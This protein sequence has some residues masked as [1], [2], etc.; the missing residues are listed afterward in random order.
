M[1]SGDR[2]AVDVAN[3]VKAA[4]PR[5]D[6]MDAQIARASIASEL[7]GAGDDKP[8]V[9]RFLVQ[10]QLGAGAMG[11]VYRAWDPELGRH[12]AIK[13]LRAS[14]QFGETSTRARDRLLREARAMANVTHA[15]VLTVY[16]AG[17]VGD[18]VFVAMELAA[19]GTLREW[20]RREQPAWRAIIDRFLQ[21]AR[22]LEAA[23]AAKLV[24]R[25][26]K[27]DNVLIDAGGEARVADFGLVSVSAET[28][29]EDGTLGPPALDLT[30]TRAGALV[31]TPAYM[32]PEQHGSDPV[33]PAADQ[34]AFCVS[35]YEA[36]YG[37]RPFA[38]TSMAELAAAVTSGEVPPPPA[39][40]GVPEW[41]HQILVRGLAVAPGDRWPSMTALIEALSADPIAARRRRRAQIVVGA[42]IV[43]L[44][45]LATFGF[46]RGSSDDRPRCPTSQ[47]RLSGVWDTN[48]RGAVGQAFR[49]TGRRY[50]DDTFTRVASHLDDYT[51]TWVRERD[52]A[53]RATHQ[54]GEQSSVLLDL[55]MRCY[56]RR[57]RE[58]DRLVDLLAAGPDVDVL[59]RAVK[60]T[61]SLTPLAEC[62]DVDALR[63]P[64][65]LPSAPALRARVRALQERLEQG[66]MWF[67]AGKRAL[68]AKRLAELRSSVGAT[69]YLPLRAQTAFYSAYTREFH[70]YGA[71]YGDVMR[72]YEL[73][74]RL[75]ARAKL[76]RIVALAWIRMIW[77]RGYVLSQHGKALALRVT[78]EVAVERAG[79]ED[80]LRAKL[81][82]A[83]GVIYDERGERSRAQRLFKR[84]LALRRAAYGAEHPEIA[85]ALNN[86]ADSYRQAGKLRRALELHKRSLAMKTRLLGATHP[87]AGASLFNL[88][89]TSLAL[90]NYADALS[91][92]RRAGK[93]LTLR[94]STGVPCLVTAAIAKV[95]QAQRQYARAIATLE[96]ALAACTEQQGKS[97]AIKAKVLTALGEAHMQTGELDVAIT[98][99]RRAVAMFTKVRGE[100]NHSTGL[101]LS[102]L[103][104][105]LLER[106]KVGE[107]E[108][109]LKRALAVLSAVL[110][111]N[112]P[113]TCAVR[114][115]LGRAQLQKHALDAAATRFRRV[116][117]ALKAGRFD[118]AN[119]LASALF[120]L[121]EI[122]L[123]RAK[124][125]LAVD[126]A[127]RA[128]AEAE[129]GRRNERTR[130]WAHFMLAR[131]LLNQDRLKALYHGRQAQAWM[132]KAPPVARTELRMVEAWLDRHGANKVPR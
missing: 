23:H 58:V 35:L 34:F 110:G 114:V 72:E 104:T 32:A 86:L 20:L 66:K 79:G 98:T 115:A 111:D 71:K 96:R 119:T 55:R 129:R 26:F 7:F 8:V 83:I 103:G 30:L 36:L 46:A 116:V 62:A 45:G 121:A 61:L 4:S 100:T 44:A 6:D 76:D 130:G 84:V 89:E 78:A 51:N 69:G 108:S 65:P 57:L 80:V 31:G 19:G 102:A 112:N 132:R 47:A 126:K 128:V 93:V 13:L 73:A 113:A 101:A 38:G 28:D 37:Q 56:D 17:T 87:D 59:D 18:Q 27:P 97:H 10:E 131:A 95:D 118:T 125:G 12:V 52:S 82:N 122:D 2:Y 1:G 42:T 24:H 14:A 75:A 43:G 99:H 22:G 117:K 90:G 15:H 127:T 53:C 68:A 16:D 11:Q 107:A 85:A 21:A 9:G 94:P 123:A 88:G 49:K 92:Y 124:P 40:T 25:D 29:Q 60:A 64:Q 41:V 109:V 39:D 74:A 50:A 5:A 70:S 33:G 91:Y 67:A 105:A 54:R 48:R 3:R 120:G 81:L 63:K 77:I 106:G